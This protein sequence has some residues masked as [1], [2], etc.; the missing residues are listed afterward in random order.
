MVLDQVCDI[1]NYFLF[2]PVPCTTEAHEASYW[3]PSE[4]DLICGNKGI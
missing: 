1:D 4:Q 3:L 2:N